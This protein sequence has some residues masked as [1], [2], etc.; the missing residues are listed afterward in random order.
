MYKIS[1]QVQ[2]DAEDHVDELHLPAFEDL[3]AERSTPPPT[4]AS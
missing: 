1:N 2:A 3:L 4:T